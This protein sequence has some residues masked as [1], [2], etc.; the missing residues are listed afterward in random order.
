M[1]YVRT[2]L[3]TI[4]GAVIAILFFAFIPYSPDLSD[5]GA[6][7]YPRAYLFPLMIAAIV[8]YISGWLGSR[9]STE[10][11]RLCGMLSMI[12]VGICAIG[13][14]FSGGI[15]TPLFHH[16]AYPVF[17]DHALLALAVILAGGHLGG[18]R[19][20]KTAAHTT[21]NNQIASEKP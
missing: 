2:A 20:E 7:V 10:T 16:P 15:L 3:G 4:V 13:W 18:L 1:V 14:D 17:S 11:G 19:I 6:R 12:L 9:I 8:S 5:W 21:E